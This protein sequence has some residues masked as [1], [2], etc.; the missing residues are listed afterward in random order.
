MSLKDL[1]RLL[2]EGS[3]M[4]LDRDSALRTT[5]IDWWNPKDAQLKTLH[6]KTVRHL[7]VR[8]GTLEIEVSA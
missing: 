2:D 7:R 5:V 4:V 1:L 3:F 6:D 8:G